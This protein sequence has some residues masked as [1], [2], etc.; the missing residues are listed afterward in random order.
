MSH[1]AVCFLY[2]GNYIRVDLTRRNDSIEFL[3]KKREIPVYEV[4]IFSY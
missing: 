3:N 1:F 4:T 2:D